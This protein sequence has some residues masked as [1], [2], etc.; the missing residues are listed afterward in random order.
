MPRASIFT[1]NRLFQSHHKSGVRRG[2][3]RYVVLVLDYSVHA[4]QRSGRHTRGELLRKAAEEFVTE[5]FDQNPISHLAL[6]VTRDAVA[7]RLTDLSGVFSSTRALVFSV[8]A[9]QP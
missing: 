9:T 2:M 7:Q 4:E 1:P 5:Y 6:L 3:T 8:I